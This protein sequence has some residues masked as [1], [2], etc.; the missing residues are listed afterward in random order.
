MWRLPG[1]AWVGDLSSLSCLVVT[2]HASGVERECPGPFSRG[3]DDN[4]DNRLSSLVVSAFQKRR[5]GDKCGTGLPPLG[6]PAAPVTAEE[7]GAAVVLVH[8]LPLAPAALVGGSEDGF[9]A[10]KC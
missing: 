2:P 6:E 8:R 1:G 5:F 9:S 3:L 7:L 4:G 10:L